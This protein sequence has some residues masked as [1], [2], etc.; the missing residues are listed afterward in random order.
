[1]ASRSAEVHQEWE[2]LEYVETLIFKTGG[3]A[4]VGARNDL[5]GISR[6]EARERTEGAVANP[7]LEVMCHS[8][9]YLGG[10]CGQPQFPGYQ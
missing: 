1:M 3:A 2:V 7:L 9:V 6:V 5:T 10:H 8:G 4:S